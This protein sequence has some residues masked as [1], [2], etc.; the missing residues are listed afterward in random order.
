MMAKK[1][2]LT[3]G[4]GYIG[5]HTA[6]CLLD[7]GYEV[8][9]L[10]DFSNSSPGS[11][12]AGVSFTE[13]DVG[14]A[15]LVR[16]VLADNAI[17][18]VVHFAGS[19]VVPES[20]EDPHGYYLNNVVKSHSLIGA[21]RESGVRHLV[22]SSTA[23]V[24]GAP[25]RVPVSEEAATVPINPYGHS[26]LMVEQMLRDL[27]ATGALDHVALR[28]FNVAGADPQGRAGQRGKNLTHLIKVA[29]QTAVGLRPEITIFGTDY[30]TPDGT[31]V[32]DYIH[33]SDLAA[34]HL[35]ALRHL[36]AGQGSVTLNCGYGR[37]YSVAEVL[38]AVERVTGR[39]LA[40]VEGPRRAGDPPA[41]V[42]ATEKIRRVLD[43]SPRHDD[44]DGIV[45]SAIDWERKL[46]GS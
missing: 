20:V 15:A 34:A 39:A 45:A 16:S 43:W 3:G 8:F 29:S 25:A 35:S 41:L 1:V 2:L 5:S 37:G 12:P 19:I 28:Y 32:R 36:E 31:C 11:V 42:A 6:Y 22:F 14:D 4:A 10:D 21:C 40:K 27:S 46:K 18:A 9:V 44:L 7:A 17:G 33:I 38:S 13:G 23:A 24:Y 30:E 26:K